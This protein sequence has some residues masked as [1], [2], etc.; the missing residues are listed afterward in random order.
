[1]STLDR[2][3]AVRLLLLCAV[4]ARR[5]DRRRAAGARAPVGQCS[6]GAHPGSRRPGLRRRPHR[7]QRPRRQL[8]ERPQRRPA[9]HG[10]R[11]HADRHPPR[12]TTRPRSWSTATPSGDACDGDDDADGVADKR[13]TDGD[14][15]PDTLEDNCRTVRNPRQYGGKTTYGGQTADGT[16]LCPATD[17]DGDGHNDDLDNCRFIPNPSQQ[18]LDS[19]GLGDECDGDDDGDGVR[20]RR[21]QLPAA[22]QQRPGGRRRRRRGAHLR[23]RRAASR[24]RSRSWP[25]SADATAPGLRLALALAPAA[26]TTSP[27][28]CRRPCAAT[29]RAPSRGRCGSRAATPGACACRGCWPAARASSR[30]PAGRSCSGARRRACM[31]TLR[32]HPSRARIE[33]SVTATDAAKNARSVRRRVLLVP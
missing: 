3:R 11:L 13:D 12:R 19:D 28:G 31:R 2:M 7:R 10:L 9:Q 1:M 30:T 15:T 8:P 32:R 4:A 6:S 26:S 14:G 21:R 22:A 5:R 17:G 20:R 33:I 23:P 24:R 16:L 18:D 27:A 25:P 29:R